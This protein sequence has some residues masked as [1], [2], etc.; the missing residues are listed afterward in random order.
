MI[1]ST[2]DIKLSEYRT[3]IYIAIERL[4]LFYNCNYVS[5][6]S[7]VVC[8]MSIDELTK[9]VGFI[10]EL[11]I[12]NNRIF[13]DYLPYEGFTTYNMESFDICD[14]PNDIISN[15]ITRYDFRKNV[16]LSIL[17][18]MNKNETLKYA[19]MSMMHNDLYY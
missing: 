9:G 15:M 7:I 18:I 6:S 12:E 17:I 14:I 5:R 11:V 19:L 1:N 3:M 10:I 2:N 4:L 8:R 16:F 13:M